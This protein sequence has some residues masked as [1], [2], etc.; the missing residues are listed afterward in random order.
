MA[1]EL[2][3][4]FGGPL[5]D[6]AA[7]GRAL[8]D[9]KFPF[10]IAPPAS[11]LEQH[12]GLL[13]MRLRRE[14]TG[15]ELSIFKGRDVV[16][17]LAEQDVD[18]GYDRVASFRWGADE[19]EMLAGLCTAAALAKLVNGLVLEEWDGRLLQPDEA[20]AFARQHLKAV[21]PRAREPGTRPADIKRYLSPLLKLRSDL[22]LVGR[23]LLVRPV[24]HL[25]R[26]ATFASLSDKYSFRLWRYFQL[27]GDPEGGGCSDSF[28]EGQWKVWQPHFE[29]LLFATL[30]D[31][32]FAHLGPMTTLA[33][34]AT[35]PPDPDNFPTVHVRAFVLS[36][37]RDQAA[38]YIDKMEHRKLGNPYREHWAK[39][40]RAFLARDIGDVCAESHATEAKIIKAMKL[41]HIWEPSP[42]PVELPP[43]QRP[44][45]AEPFFPA[46]PWITRS[47]SLLQDVPQCQGD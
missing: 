20:V 28:H 30:A 1:E 3:V 36:G 23:M 12:S 39:E 35:H 40:Q 27:L 33:D 24:R 17:E 25:L 19:S 43:A 2:H 22:V 47:P 8:K 45:S 5:P 13:P 21:K 41:E 10:S 44:R 7:L 37:E 42:F 14:E 32:V 26:G 46:T 16:A 38:D 11:S 18:P 31:E 15:V 6:T 29:P 34:F 4:L 9:L